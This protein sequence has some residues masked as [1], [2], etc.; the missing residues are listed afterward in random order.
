MGRTLDDVLSARATSRIPGIQDSTDDDVR[1]ILK[2]LRE[3]SF[4]VE[5]AGRTYEL[6]KRA[7]AGEAAA[8][9]PAPER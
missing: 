2:R 5:G 4:I 9:A 1:D 7:H 6:S 8:E 3:K